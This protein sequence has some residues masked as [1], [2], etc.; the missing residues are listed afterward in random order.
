MFSTNERLA[1]MS[2]LMARVRAGIDGA[3]LEL[4]VAATAALFRAA[5]SDISFFV[6]PIEIATCQD[7]GKAGVLSAALYL[8]GLLC[9]SPEG[10]KTLE[11]YG[12]AFRRP[13]GA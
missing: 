8:R 7:K 12:F 3:D 6:S 11:R 10:R 4:F 5:D 9:E 13:E 2:D 1:L